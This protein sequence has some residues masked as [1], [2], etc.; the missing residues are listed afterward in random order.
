MPADENIPPPEQLQFRRAQSIADPAIRVCI[1]CK[2]EIA[3]EYYDANGNT[4]CPSCTQRIRTGQ[5]SP[6][7]VSM[8]RAAL[9]GAGAALGGTLIYAAVGIFLHLEIG[10]IAILIGYMVGKSV[11]FASGGGRPQQILS[12]ALTYF[13]ITGAFILGILYQA[14]KSGLSIDFNHLLVPVLE[15]AIA[16]PFL[17]LFQ[18]SNSISALISLVIIFFG[19]RQAWA[20]TAASKI[21]ITGP[22]A[23]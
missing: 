10:L 14:S 6:P 23:S 2:Q 22:F 13:A 9:F 16:A 3:G 20:L 11:R 8:L 12:V 21:V 7:P 17:A 1:A 18:G 19:L 4:L 15:L 5:Q